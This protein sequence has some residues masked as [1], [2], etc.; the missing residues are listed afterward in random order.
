MKSPLLSE[1]EC[2]EFRLKRA[3]SLMKRPRMV[4]IEVERD[5]ANR[6]H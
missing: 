1:P 4:V 3:I 5:F 2:P 6:Y